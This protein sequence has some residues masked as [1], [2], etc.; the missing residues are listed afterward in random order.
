VNCITLVNLSFSDPLLVGITDNG[1]QITFNLFGASLKPVF[2]ISG[3]IVGVQ[4]IDWLRTK[5][6]KL[7]LNDIVT[8]DIIKTYLKTAHLKATLENR[9]AYTSMSFLRWRRNIVTQKERD[10]VW[11]AQT[12]Y[13]V[14]E[15]EGDDSN[16]GTE[17]EPFQTLAKAQTILDGLE[18]GSKTVVYLKCGDTWEEEGTATSV[19]GNTCLLRLTK[20]YSGVSSYG[21][22]D[23]PFVN[24]FDRKYSSGWTVHSGDVYVRSEIN[25]IAS[26]RL[27]NDRLVPLYDASDTTDC[28]TNISDT[29]GSYFYDSA[30]NNLYINLGGTDPNTVTLEAAVS[31]DSTIEVADHGCFV[32][33]I[34]FDGHVHRS[35]RDKQAGIRINL[36]GSKVGRIENCE[37]YYGSSHLIHFNCFTGTGGIAVIKNCIAGYSLWNSAGNT[38]FNS[39]A[40]NGEQETYV[41]DCEVPYGTLPGH[42]WTSTN[43]NYDA[44]LGSAFY[45]H[46]GGSEAT[47]GFILIDGMDCT[48]DNP[49]GPPGGS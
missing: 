23:K 37:A 15:S 24:Q 25:D 39:F 42:E 11:T 21:T 36:T 48:H 5:S 43:S 18:D 45:C 22:G 20:T 29:N 17:A 33:N 6:L 2:D 44:L 3:G 12:K 40:Q 26:I 4:L 8:L 10:T 41:Q 31:N 7:C 27:V 38:I 16:P 49:W 1:T 9:P 28:A 34:R 19:D 30:G 47:T 32:E 14:S 35:T 13:Y 46:T